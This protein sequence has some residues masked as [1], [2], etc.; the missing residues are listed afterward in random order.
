MNFHPIASIFPLL[1]KSALKELAADIAA[2]GQREPVYL[3]EGQVLDGRNRW[4]AC[5]LAGV[6]PKT[7]EFT[8]DR[9]AAL[10]FVWS[11]NFHRRHLN[12]G[13]AAVAEAKR[14]RLDAEYAGEV[15]K[16]KAEAAEKQKAA[17]DRGKEGGRGKKKTPAQRIAQ[18]KRMPQTSTVRAKAAHTN[19]RY[20]EAA[21]DLLDTQP[22][23]LAAV[24]SGDKS[25]SQV[26]REVK[27]EETQAKLAAL[28]GDKFRVIYADPPW[29]YGNSGVISDADAYSTTGRHYPSMSIAELCAMDIKSII[30]DN[31]VLFLW[32]TSPL[33]AECWPVIK[34]WGFAYKTSFVWDKVKHN[35]GHYNS[36]RHELLLI[37]TRGSCV[38]DTKELADSVQSIERSDKHSEKPEEFRKIIDRMYTYGKRIELFA[39]KKLP[40]GWEAWGNEL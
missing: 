19:R 16:M 29:S 15:G 30:E 10:R 40:A 32:V 21:E 13:Q 1:G 25:L 38:P 6:E 37:C 34:A 22:E 11:E 35:F 12:P 27:R 23:R 31:A 20:L 4:A 18:G 5:E 14:G 28:P 39:R 33:L 8:G 17:G 3:Y 36:V 2:N 26:L 7:R 9:M 24:E